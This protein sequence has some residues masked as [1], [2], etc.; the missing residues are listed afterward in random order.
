MVREMGRAM[1][2]QPHP[3]EAPAFAIRQIL[4]FQTGKK[5]EHVG[6][7]LLVIEVLDARP[8]ARR[9]GGDVV[10]KRD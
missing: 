5:F 9:I 8:V 3:F 7:G 2:R 10:L 1:R 4:F 6:R